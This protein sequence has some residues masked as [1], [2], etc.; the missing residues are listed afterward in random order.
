MSSTNKISHKQKTI[1]GVY[2][3]TSLTHFKSMF[4]FMPLDNIRN[5]VCFLA[6][7]RGCKRK[8]GLIWVKQT[9]NMALQKTQCC[10]MG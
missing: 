5:P 10:R 3:F 2:L 7:F 4:Y 8:I 6:F 1:S 9:L